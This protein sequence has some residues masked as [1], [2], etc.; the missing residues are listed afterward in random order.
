MREPDNIVLLQ[1]RSLREELVQLANEQAALTKRFDAIRL[2]VNGESFLGRCTASEV[3][4]RL[5][6]VEARLTRFEGQVP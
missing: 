4:S 5:D 2:A 6:T 3:E 1:S